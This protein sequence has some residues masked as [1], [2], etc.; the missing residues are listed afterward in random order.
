MRIKIILII[1]LVVIYMGGIYVLH[2][3][4]H[5]TNQ[6]ATAITSSPFIYSFNVSGQLEEAGSM[7]ESRSPYWWLD[8]GGLMTIEE[9]TGHTNYGD[10]PIF[11]KWNVM[12]RVSNPTD[13]DNGTHP[14]NIF[15]LITRSTWQQYSEQA[16]F[17]INTYNLSK[18]EN[19]NV[20]N[21]LL[22]FLHYVDQNN[23]YYAGVRVD[24]TAVIKKKVNGKYFTLAQ[25]KIFPGTY[26]RDKNPTLLPSHTWLG[27][28]T[29]IQNN[30]DGSVTVRLYFDEKGD[31]E[32]PQWKIMLTAVDG[33]GG[34][35]GNPIVQESFAGIRLDFMDVEF[36]NFR[37]E[38]GLFKLM[39]F[40]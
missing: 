21:G 19:R 24:G 7:K 35:D 9:N 32:N 40:S 34:A 3:R 31:R 4:I 1:V 16:Y 36:S 8:S 20:S 26:D 33:V 39:D 2:Y 6:V 23:F 15:R 10:L 29:S 25:K 18:S 11:S 38:N 17:N 22:L 13:T 37:I 30:D 28:K 27:I 14:Q 5:S 12:Y